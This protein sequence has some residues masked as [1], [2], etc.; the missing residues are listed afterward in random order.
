MSKIAINKLHLNQKSKKKLWTY[1]HYIIA[2]MFFTGILTSGCMLLKELSVNNVTV[3]QL[4]V[5]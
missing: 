3:S 5:Y 4:F 1:V 2:K